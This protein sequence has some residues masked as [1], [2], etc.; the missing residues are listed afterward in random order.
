MISRIVVLIL[1]FQ[2][3]F[4]FAQVSDAEME[5]LKTKWRAELRQKGHELAGKTEIVQGKSEFSDS[6]RRL[7]LEDTFVVENLHRKQLEKD[8]TNLGMNKANLACASEYELLVD[9]YYGILLSKM[10]PDD[11][12]LL[13][14]W[15]QSW[16]ALMDKERVLIG[17]FMQ[18]AYSGGGSVQSLTYTSRLMHGQK[19]HLILLMNYLSELI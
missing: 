13:I 14:S 3:S 4:L 9:K 16:K 17:K 8:L 2:S 10:K 19:D 6:I 12:E 5:K 15:Q 7:F 11:K 18:E 1:F